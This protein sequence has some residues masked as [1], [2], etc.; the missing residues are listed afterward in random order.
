MYGTTIWFF[1]QNA[2]VSHEC[3]GMDIIIALVLNEINPLSKHRM[4]LVME[5]KVNFINI[6]Q[7]MFVHC[8]VKVVDRIL[9][10]VNRNEC[11]NLAS[12]PLYLFVVVAVDVD[13]NTGAIPWWNPLHD[14]LAFYC[15]FW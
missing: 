10:K 14:Q 7:R 15:A 6:F 12:L 11:T 1:P 4:D 13:S 8:F 9:I 3:N 2:I 5:L